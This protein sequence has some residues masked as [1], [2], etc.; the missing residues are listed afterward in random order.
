[1]IEFEQLH[2]GLI[3]KDI[4]DDESHEWT[5]INCNDI[6]NVH[7]EIVTDGDDFAGSALVCFEKGC[8]L[9]HGD[10]YSIIDK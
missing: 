8:E 5:V 4:S 1:M 2:T 9:Y 6:H 10:K 3:L 7:L